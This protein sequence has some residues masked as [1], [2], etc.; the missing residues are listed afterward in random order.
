MMSVHENGLI[1]HANS[2]LATFTA[3]TFITVQLLLQNIAILL[4]LYRVSNLPLI[5]F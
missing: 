3:S 1:F 2:E 4:T 5:I